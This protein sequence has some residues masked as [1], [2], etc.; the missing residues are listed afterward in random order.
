M[1]KCNFIY[2]NKKIIRKGDNFNHIQ[3]VNCICFLGMLIDPSTSLW[4]LNQVFQLD[5]VYCHSRYAVIYLYQTT[6]LTRC[7]SEWYVIPCLYLYCITSLFYKVEILYSLAMHIAQIYRSWNNS[8]QT[9]LQ[10]TFWIWLK[11]SPF[12]IIFFFK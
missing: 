5:F 7:L 12:L 3:N 6:C 10:F 8:L 2:L 9:W 11:L 1:S 4:H